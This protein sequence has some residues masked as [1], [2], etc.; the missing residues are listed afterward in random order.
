[1]ILLNGKNLETAWWG[2]ARS[3]AL[4]LEA[5]AEVLSAIANFTHR[6][7]EMH[8]PRDADGSH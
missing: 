2:P 7:F 8:E 5:T 4:T 3:G 6:L 1:M